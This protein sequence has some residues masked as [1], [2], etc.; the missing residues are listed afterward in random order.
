MTDE[1][2]DTEARRQRLEALRA[3]RSSVESAG[4]MVPPPTA[5]DTPPADSGAGNP[6]AGLGPQAQRMALGWL[7]RVLMATPDDGTGRVPGTRMTRAGVARLMALLEERRLAEGKPGVLVAQRLYAFLAE[8]GPET[9]ERVH[10]AKVAQLQKLQRLA[11][12]LG[13]SAGG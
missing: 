12:R 7:R 1:R 4:T 11:L 9:G 5:E 2:D 10:G 6:V 13:R 8:Q 3:R